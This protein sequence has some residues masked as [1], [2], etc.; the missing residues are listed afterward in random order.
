M[1]VAPG[2]PAAPVMV[3]WR[4]LPVAV[5]AWI[6][7]WMS[8][9]S[10]LSGTAAGATSV[11]L[12]VAAGVLVAWWLREVGSR[13]G[14]GRHARTPGGSLRLAAAL[15]AVAGAAALASGAAAMDAHARDP[16]VRLLAGGAT[17]L[18]VAVRLLGDPAPDS[19]RWAQD[20][21]RVDVTVLTVAEHGA[22]TRPAPSGVRMAAGGSG[23]EHLARGDVVRVTAHADTSFRAEP[24]NAGT[25]RADDPHLVERPGG[26]MAIVRTVRQSLTRATAH[27]PDQAQA[28]VP[29]MAVGDD[30]AMGRE[31]REAMLTSSLT[32]LTAVSG[33]HVAIILGVIGAVVP[34]R[35]TVRAAMAILSMAALVAVVGPEPSVVRSVATAGVG[36][37]GL[38]AHRPGQSQAALAAV[39]C[40]IL[41]VDPWSSRSFGFALSVLA[42][43][44]VVGPAVT[45]H[46][47]WTARVGSGSAAGR[48][49]GRA[50]GAVAVPVAAQ[51]MVAPVQLLL[52]PWLPLWGVVANVLAAPAVAPASLLGLAAAVTAPVWPDAG[53]WLA[54]LSAVF[55]GW[56]AGVGQAVSTW[57][58]A[59]LPFF[60]GPGGAIAL[61]ALVVLVVLARRRLGDTVVSLARR[62]LRHPGRVP[63]ELP[64]WRGSGG[65]PCHT[66]RDDAP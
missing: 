44:G 33:S 61:V 58:A 55:T 54:G 35:G 50:G 6:G 20:R 5:S 10:V 21:Q 64:V 60:G 52:N 66:G 26:W 62:V 57:P 19:A 8:T 46:R 48:A 31:L 29:G 17:R 24:P 34:G 1:S 43:W 51:V 18:D 53:A 45:W 16:T 49:L 13:P 65:T 36:V 27:L 2:E 23:W 56:I 41:V 3:D 9:W 42:T 63:K 40:A 11:V 12:A 32:H 39:A 38:L 14:P 47:A 59:R 22:P 7:A 28:L 37:T 4:L 15:A 30:R 25:L